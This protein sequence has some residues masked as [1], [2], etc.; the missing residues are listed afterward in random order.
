MGISTRQLD[1]FYAVARWSGFS[2]AAAKLCITQSALSQRIKKLEAELGVALLVRSPT[3]TRPTEVGLRILRYCQT[4]EALEADVLRDLTATGE[5]GAVGE[6]RIAAYSSVMRS[7]IIPAL[8]PLLRDNPCIQC[9]LHRAGVEELPQILRHARADFVIL[10]RQLGWAG[11][12]SVPLGSEELVAVESRTHAPPPELFLHQNQEDRTTERFFHCQ[13]NGIAY[14]S[15]YLDDVYGILDGVVQG[16]GRAV[17]PRHLIKREM[18]LRE[19]KP[20][21]PMRRDVVLHHY[22]L[23]HETE[24]RRAA[25][26]ALRQWAPELLSGHGTAAL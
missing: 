17:V 25:L 26:D 11:V 21:R 20:W 13:N 3:G 22:P 5:N 10:D 9:H 15:S 16:L 8:A 12:A 24:V 18:N 1:A 6:L 23:P 7:V 4:K 2:R 19:L 14:R